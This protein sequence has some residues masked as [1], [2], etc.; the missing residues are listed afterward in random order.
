MKDLHT[1]TIDLKQLRQDILTV[2]AQH[3]ATI[4]AFH[5]LWYAMPFTQGLSTF[6]GVPLIKCPMD[7]WSYG[8]IIWDLK[9]TLI[10]ETGTAYGGSALFFAR[11]LDKLGDPR[12]AVLSIDI[13]PAV[14]LPQ[15]RRITFVSGFSSTDPKV[16]EAVRH[17][18]TTHPRVMVVLDSDH[19]CTHVLE[20][21]NAYAALVTKGQFLVVEDTNICGHPVQTEWKG[22]PGPKEALDLWLQT[23]PEFE[24]DPMAER[25]LLTMHPGGWL[26]RTEGRG[27]TKDAPAREEVSA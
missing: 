2:Q 7:L 6:E 26:R 4:A 23:H 27:A 12:A 13:E 1:T 11:Q 8:E 10:I 17:T 24:A 14:T 19:S 21:L 22:G 16:V 25:H 3:A 20:E 18:A 5:R 9:P 15:H